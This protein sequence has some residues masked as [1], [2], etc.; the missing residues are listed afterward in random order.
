MH[1]SDILSLAARAWHE[2]KDPKDPEFNDC[3]LTHRENLGAAAKAVVDSQQAF[4][5]FDRVVLRL[6]LADEEAKSQA[7]KILEQNP[8]L[9][10]DEVMHIASGTP[11]PL[12][13]APVEAEVSAANIGHAEDAQREAAR[14]ELKDVDDSG[15]IAPVELK[16][17]L[18]ADFPA[19]DLLHDAGIN[20][21]TQLSKVDDYTT[22][23]GVGPVNAEKI[24][25]RL[26]EDSQIKEN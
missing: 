13:P 14:E 9:H 10:S 17:S 6:Y 4:S 19:H 2:T 11:H 25:N 24:A 20:T 21:Y 26:I 22:I 5:L 1:F 15:L 12:A 23:A 8:R 18:P 7:E 16:G 3:A